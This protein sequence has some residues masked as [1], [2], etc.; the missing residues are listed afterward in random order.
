ML[1]HMDKFSHVENSVWWNYLSADLKKLVEGSIYLAQHAE[2][3]GYTFTDYS[4]VVFPMAKAYE[5]FLKKF[6]LD[7]GFITEGDYLGTHFRI[8]KALNPNLE[9][10]LR[11]DDWV[12][13]KIVTYCKGS[14][15]PKLMWNTWRECRNVVFHWFPH[16]TKELTLEEAAVRLEMI[17]H[18]F[19]EV[20]TECKIKV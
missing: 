8:G 19:D 16:G 15:L 1:S 6:C 4:F 18:T 11:G 17:L 5:G 9:E 20:F 12:Y 2:S 13:P 10:R 14:N 7:M 3:W